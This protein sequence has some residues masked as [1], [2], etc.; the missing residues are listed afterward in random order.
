MSN[1]I[2]RGGRII[3]PSSNRNEVADL[4]VAGGQISTE[5]PNGEFETISA[6]NL[7]VAPGLIDLHVHLREPGQTHK[8]TI[9]SGSQAAAAGGFTTI[10]C[11][12]NTAPPLDNPSSVSWIL[13]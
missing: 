10:V 5:A 9:A 6:E 8:E 13:E 1:L 3:D 11:M 2:I 4:F 7:I 12:P